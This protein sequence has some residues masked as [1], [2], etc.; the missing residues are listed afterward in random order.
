MEIIRLVESV[1]GNWELDSVNNLRNPTAG[2]SW[3]FAQQS[4]DQGWWQHCSGHYY[5]FPSIHYWF[6]F[7][8]WIYVSCHFL[9]ISIP[10]VKMLKVTLLCLTEKVVAAPLFPRNLKQL[11]VLAITDLLLVLTGWEK[12]KAVNKFIVIM[13]GST[14]ILSHL[15][16]GFIRVIIRSYLNYISLCP[17]PSLQPPFL[18][19]ILMALI[20]PFRNLLELISQCSFPLG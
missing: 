16:S 18:S 13:F 20:F 3:T 12:I 7:C 14:E 2:H 11:L 6:C 1:T 19:F 10:D 15:L 8:S 17:Q 5:F 4:L 9:G